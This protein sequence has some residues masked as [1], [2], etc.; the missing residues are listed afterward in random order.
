M[1][2]ISTNPVLSILSYCLLSAT[3]TE[4]VLTDWC[5]MN[6]F[7]LRCIYLL[8]VVVYAHT[9]DFIRNSKD[10]FQESIVCFHHVGPR[11]GTQVIS[12]GSK[13]HYPLSHLV[14]PYEVFWK[15]C[16][17]YSLSINYCHLLFEKQNDTS[18]AIWFLLF[19]FL[20]YFLFVNYPLS[21]HS[22]KI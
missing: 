10:N 19:I 8:W 17:G 6:E 13:H 9:V 3:R 7:L 20:H 5:L 22:C 11:D 18:S 2:C 4:G 21:V 1:F 12:L 14:N 16:L 15:P